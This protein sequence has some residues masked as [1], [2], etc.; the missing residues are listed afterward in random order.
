M[1]DTPGHR[2]RTSGKMTELVDVRLSH[3]SSSASSSSLA[4]LCIFDMCV[5]GFWSDRLLHPAGRKRHLCQELQLLFVRQCCGKLNQAHQHDCGGQQDVRQSQWG[6]LQVSVT[7]IRKWIKN[8]RRG[9]FAKT[10]SWDG[11]DGK[12]PCLNRFTPA[13][14]LIHNCILVCWFWDWL[15]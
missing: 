15:F 2:C 12:L 8:N 14:L 11:M 4:S 7:K 13:I 10:F 5:F 3:S 6:V 9:T 1:Y